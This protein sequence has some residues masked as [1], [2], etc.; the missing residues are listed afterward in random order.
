MGK[1]FRELT[2]T[3][4]DSDFVEGNYFGV[5]T[6]SVT[7]K[8]P[9]NLVAK[10]SSVVALQTKTGNVS[11]SIAPAFDA[12]RTED[13]A[14]S[15]GE[16]VT[17]TD[18]KTYAFK[19]PHYGAWS[20]SDVYEVDMTSIIRMLSGGVAEILIPYVNGNQ[21]LG[22]SDLTDGKYLS[23]ITGLPVD[24]ESFS[25]TNNY[26]P[27]AAGKT[28]AVKNFASGGQVC[29]YDINKNF[30]G[31][32]LT[33]DAGS[34]VVPY[35]CCYV[36]CSFKT[37]NINNVMLYDPTIPVTAKSYSFGG[38]KISTAL[39]NYD[40]KVAVDEY[41]GVV[42]KV[43]NMF[44]KDNVVDGQ[45]V[46]IAGSVINSSAYCYNKFSIE[47]DKYISTFYVHIMVFFG[48][49][50]S[51]VGTSVNDAYT[52]TVKQVQVPSN[53]VY[54]TASV[55]SSGKNRAYVVYGQ[56]NEKTNTP[57]FYKKSRLKDSLMYD[58]VVA[59][60]G[61]GDF[62]TV[63]EAARYA[64]DGDVV[65]V[66]PGIYEDEEIELF[67]KTISLI[68]ENPYTTIITND[69]N[70][71]ERP[72]LEMASGRLENLQF[73]QSGTGT[74]TG[75]TG[76]GAYAMH[77]ESSILADNSLYVKNCIFEAQSVSAVG[78]GMR[79][80]CDV[81][82]ENCRFKSN[83]SPGFY[84]HDS[85]INDYIGVQNI[86][87]KNCIS[88]STGNAHAIRLVSE[89]KEGTT[90]YCSFINNTFADTSAPSVD[91][92]TEGS[93]AATGNTNM[94]LTNFNLTKLCTGNNIEE[95]NYNYE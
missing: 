32:A 36:R 7:K 15:K 8:V 26:L 18:G 29:F 72:P 49:D 37:S 4:T 67:G 57:P 81:V 74:P 73:I 91:K 33:N 34:F 46:S 59:K 2:Q 17:H 43:V 87:L 50:N 48:A 40:K 42:D 3:A 58:I 16:I 75:E 5:D 89:K 53:A 66:K 47:G 44:D 76:W 55:V 80:G 1:R 6:P 54:A 38:Y 79:K 11:A 56:I 90:V 62:T 82:F 20:S 85:H 69:L 83:G 88:E 24:T 64:M 27:V 94:G 71:Y 65:F 92:Y 14:Y 51:V 95:L 61:S 60:D 28:Y 52:G 23:Y 45:Y 22:T 31:G 41:A 63:T 70:T 84:V 13:N 68:G 19:V 86:I 25:Y 78:M 21:W 35:N 77:C 30:I 9:A 39:L 12:T 93:G 10:Q